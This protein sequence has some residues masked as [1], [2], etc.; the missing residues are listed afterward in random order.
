MARRALGAVTRALLTRARARAR[1]RRV[2]Y[3]NT[4]TLMSAFG[5]IAIGIDDFYYFLKMI[6]SGVCLQVRELRPLKPQARR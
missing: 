3:A 1:L 5:S 2:E 4:A 6:F